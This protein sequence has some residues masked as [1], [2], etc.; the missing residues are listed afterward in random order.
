MKMVL[1]AF[2]A[3]FA[4]ICEA[5]ENDNG[6]LRSALKMQEPGTRPGSYRFALL[7]QEFKPSRPLQPEFYLFSPAI[8]SVPF[9]AQT[10]RSNQRRPSP[11][12][13][14]RRIRKWLPFRGPRMR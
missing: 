2:S 1:S 5:N 11:A 13:P 8:P 12:Y 10:S 9:D 4:F 7:E 3:G 14:S 6:S